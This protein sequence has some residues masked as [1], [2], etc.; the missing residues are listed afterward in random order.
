MLM[1][2]HEMT[3]GQPRDS[4]SNRRQYLIICVVMAAAFGHS[5][6]QAGALA[7]VTIEQG[8]FNG[9][10]FI[11]KY[12]KRDYAAAGSLQ[13]QIAK[14]C[15]LRIKNE[16]AD[17]IFAIY[18][19]DPN[20]MGGRR[21]RF[22]AGLLDTG[23]TNDKELDIPARQA[24]LLEKNNG[25]IPPTK[26]ELEED[27]AFKLWPKLEYKQ[28]T[29]PST[30]ALVV[31]FPF[32]DGFVS[33]MILG[34]KVIP[35]LRKAALEAGADAPVVVSTCSVKESMCTHYAPLKSAKTFLLGQPD[36]DTY[37]KA[38]GPEPVVDLIGSARK[39]GRRMSTWFGGWFGLFDIESMQGDPITAKEEL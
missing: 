10:K 14:D 12:T 34:F 35:A 17:R 2:Y 25:R 39:M 11:Y 21:Q 27:G 19:D 5:M 9:G 23:A 13:E 24:A 16:T 8:T 22:A 29:L 26:L 18:L 20:G 31:Q 7:A 32:T 36:T 28:T 37:M 33:A 1:N 30:K 3:M 15:N 6:L 4:A 38:L